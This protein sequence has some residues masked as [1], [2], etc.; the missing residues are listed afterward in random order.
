M[1][2][3]ATSSAIMMAS[4]VPSSHV[5]CRQWAYATS[6]LRPLR[7]WQNAF[8]ERL[9]GSIRREC[10]DHLIVLSEAH[11]HQDPAILFTLLQRNQT[12][13]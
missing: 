11:L 9:I 6:R 7:L 10:V 4:S 3:R 2:L 13:R 8:A 5:D 1:R 12:H